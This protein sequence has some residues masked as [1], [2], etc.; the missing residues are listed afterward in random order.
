MNCKIMH[1]T[2]G[3]IRVRMTQKRM[4]LAQADILEYY[5]LNIP[6][7]TEVKV[8]DRTC[9][10]AVRFTCPR[11]QILDALA[12]FTYEANTSLV[13]EQTGRVLNREFED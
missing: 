9:C 5:L 13:P 12:S 1:E 10:A 6:G 4:T 11:E 2:R 7:V 3:R 8:H